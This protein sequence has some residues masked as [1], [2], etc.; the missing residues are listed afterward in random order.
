MSVWTANIGVHFEFLVPGSVKV[1]C[2]E[3]LLAAS[4]VWEGF[5]LVGFSFNAMLS[6]I[7]NW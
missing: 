1:K 7:G 5:G 4:M 2:C 6:V 3:M